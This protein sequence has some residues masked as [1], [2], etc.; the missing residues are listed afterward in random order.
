MNNP[1][2]V[3][4]VDD[5]AI[6]R[7]GLHYILSHQSDIQ[8]VGM[9]ASAHQA[10]TECQ[11]SQPDVVLLD[12]RLPDGSGLDVARQL[13]ASQPSPRILLLTTFDV[14]EYVLEA[15]RAGALGYVLKDLPTEELLETIRA[16]HRGEAIYRTQS[17]SWA[18]S[19][20]VQR[21]HQPSPLF[22]PETAP[23][24]EREAEVLRRMATGARNAEIARELYVSE[25]TIKTHVHSILQ[26]LNAEDR[27]QAVVWAYR[28]GMVQ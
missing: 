12:I 21:Q 9:A 10:L 1:I 14:G 13:T 15:L 8:V 19:K 20:A 3:F 17:A 18:L 4:V 16:V 28:H 27:T 6:I 11:L 22:P 23:L 7:E 26:K 24:T 5:Q 2:R 25:G